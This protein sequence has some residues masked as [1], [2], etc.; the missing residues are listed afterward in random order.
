MVFLVGIMVQLQYC[1]NWQATI[2]SAVIMYVC[3]AILMLESVL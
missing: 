2:H 1:D 3:L